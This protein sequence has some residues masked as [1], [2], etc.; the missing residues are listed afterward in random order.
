MILG[1]LALAAAAPAETWR[2]EE[3]DGS[4]RF[5][6]DPGGCE[7]PVAHTPRRDLVTADPPESHADDPAPRAS[8]AAPD[9]RALFAP[10]GAWEVV[11]EPV[12]PPD[13][14][15]LH[16]QGLRASLAR[17]YTRARGPGSEVCTV[18]LWAFAA[19]AHAAAVRGALAPPGWWVRDAG[20]L[21][22]LAHGVRLE[23]GVGSRSG[24][25]PGCTA[26]AEAT[27]ARALAAH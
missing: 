27:R 17:H 25:V 4:L 15:A 2:C 21:L 19:P 5:T 22:V 3:P 6:D 26:L 1:S 8:G 20:A 13:D 24:L 10:A 14:P 16:D 12:A 11:E 18:E 9:L 7:A 23:R